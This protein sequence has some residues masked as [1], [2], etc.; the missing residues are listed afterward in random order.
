MNYCYGIPSKYII[1]RLWKFISSFGSI[2]SS[3]HDDVD[4]EK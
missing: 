1:R 3:S 2:G 4:V